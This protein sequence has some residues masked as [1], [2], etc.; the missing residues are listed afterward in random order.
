MS[1]GRDEADR[2]QTVAA[3]GYA[4]NLFRP[5]FSGPTYVAD[6]FRV[7]QLLIQWTSGGTAETY[8]DRHQATQDG[9]NVWLSLL[10]IYDG[11]DARNASVQ[12]TRTL[13]AALRYEKA[14]RSMITITF[15]ND[16]NRH[17]ANV[18]GRSQVSIFL[19]GISRSD[20]QPI[21]VSIVRDD[22][23]KDDL[24]IAVSEFNDVYQTLLKTAGTG[25]TR[26]ERRIGSQSSGSTQLGGGGRGG[27]G[28]V[29][30]GRGR[31]QGRGDRN[32]GGRFQ[33]GGDGG[34]GGGSG[35]GGGGGRTNVP[36][37]PSPRKLSTVSTLARGL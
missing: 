17:E 26:A 22:R 9:R 36:T 7:Y 30:R 19:N 21:K 11:P 28:R 1:Y 33:R 13:L 15:N 12:E 23:C 18:D 31:S 29:G 14:S 27:G 5:P 4:A 8:V 34:R 20:M 24:F 32:R 25:Q 16:L 6:N 35:G 10:D 2:A 3:G 37:T